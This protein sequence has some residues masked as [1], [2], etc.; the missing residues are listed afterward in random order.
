MTDID[1]N[2][3]LAEQL[4][5]H[6]RGQLRPRLDAMTDAEYRWEPVADAWNVRPRGTG[7]APV[8]VGAGRGRL[9]GRVS[10]DMIAVDITDLPPV[11]VGA[12]VE[13][14]GSKLPVEELALAAG[15][16]P[17]ELICAISQRVPIELI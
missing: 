2:F 3:Q 7:T 8:Q 1:W 9:V 6:W 10:M 5:S 13:L 4:D 14:W 11:E 17:Y 15:T 12:R 16:I